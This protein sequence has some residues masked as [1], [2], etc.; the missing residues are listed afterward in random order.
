MPSTAYFAAKLEKLFFATPIQRTKAA[1]LIS[2]EPDA[3][4]PHV[5]LFNWLRR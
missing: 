3:L 4:Q 5:G 1:G 2:Q